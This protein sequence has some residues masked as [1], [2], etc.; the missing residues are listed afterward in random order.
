VRELTDSTHSNPVSPLQ[1]LGAA[2]GLKSSRWSPIFDAYEM[3]NMWKRANG[4]PRDSGTYPISKYQQMRY[5]IEDGDLARAAE[6]YK[7]LVKEQRPG[8]DRSGNA[9]SPAEM[10]QRGFKQSVEHPFTGS[11]DTESQFVKSLNSD[12]KSVY[13]AAVDRR[14]MILNSMSDVVDLARKI[15]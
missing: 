2:A 13:D 3:A 5:A 15:P 8:H 11:K 4:L 6:E 1:Q 12:Q 14:R 7:K 10:I 9:V